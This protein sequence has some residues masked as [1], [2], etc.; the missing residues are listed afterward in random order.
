MKVK[1]KIRRRI[2]TRSIRKYKRIHKLQEKDGKEEEGEGR[3]EE[4]RVKTCK[5]G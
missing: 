2:R 5:E 4:L 3:K 1:R